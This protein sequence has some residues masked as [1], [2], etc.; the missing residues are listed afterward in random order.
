MTPFGF[1]LYTGRDV[2]SLQA[3]LTR[4]SA[5]GY[6]HVEGFGGAYTN[7]AA[8]RTA[9]DVARLTMP[10]GH[11][12]LADLR[13]DFDGCVDIARTLGVE[14]IIAPY[15]DAAERPVDAGGYTELARRLGILHKRC[16][17]AGFGFAWHNHDF[18]FTPLTDGAIGM[19]VILSEAPDIAWEADLAWVIRGGADPMAWIDRY[20]SR[21]MA[22]H[23]KDIAPDGENLD[24]DGWADL[25]AGTVDWPALMAAVTAQ[26]GDVLWIAEHDKPRDPRDFAEHAANTFY[27]WTAV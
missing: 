7:P 22:V 26:A 6:S 9:M 16:A 18:E 13:D 2:P 12:G 11:F 24:E 19:D 23:V 3:F 14:T 10:S 27:K 21:I 5:L 1:Q 17:D 20:G 4:L 15:L 25:G 8:F